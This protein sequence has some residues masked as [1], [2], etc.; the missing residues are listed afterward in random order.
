MSAPAAGRSGCSRAELELLGPALLLS[1]SP[2]TEQGWGSCRYGA[3]AA[4]GLRAP[5]RAAVAVTLETLIEA[6]CELQPRCSKRSFPLPP[7]EGMRHR[8]R[9]EGPPSG[10]CDPRSRPSG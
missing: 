6:G 2:S 1:P 8:Q 3:V 7:L 10:G 5:C 4:A 9:K